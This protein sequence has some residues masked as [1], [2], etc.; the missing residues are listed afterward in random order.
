ME[1]EKHNHGETQALSDS[2]PLPEQSAVSEQLQ[3]LNLYLYLDAR[4]FGASL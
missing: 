3:L 1:T 4:R 2:R